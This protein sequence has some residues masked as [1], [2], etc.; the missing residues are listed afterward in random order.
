MQQHLY[1]FTA[2]GFGCACV[3][4]D[5]NKTLSIFDVEEWPGE[6][7]RNK[8]SSPK[9]DDDGRDARSG[10]KKERRKGDYES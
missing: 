3:A 8:D 9:E 2:G 7:K 5:G 6:K 1:T 10:G 4:A